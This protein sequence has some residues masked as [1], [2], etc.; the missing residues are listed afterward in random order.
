MIGIITIDINAV[1]TSPTKLPTISIL[2][3]IILSQRWR[4]GKAK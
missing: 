1:K 4:D 3:L 2:L